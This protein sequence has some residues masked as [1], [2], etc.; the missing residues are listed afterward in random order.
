VYGEIETGTLRCNICEKNKNEH[1]T[2]LNV[3]LKNGFA[4]RYYGGVVGDPEY[5]GFC[6]EGSV[7]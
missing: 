5:P 7:I 1:C 2:K 3:D 4:K 6:K